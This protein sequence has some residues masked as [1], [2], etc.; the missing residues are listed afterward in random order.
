MRFGLNQN[1]RFMETHHIQE[2]IEKSKE[3]RKELDKNYYSKDSV[4]NSDYSFNDSL[5]KREL[6]K[7]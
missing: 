1:R 2:V 4:K 5:A 6:Y 7:I 3:T